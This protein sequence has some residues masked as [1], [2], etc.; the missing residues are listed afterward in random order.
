M[1]A[2]VN[3]SY[4]YLITRYRDGC[5]LHL[6]SRGVQLAKLAWIADSSVPQITAVGL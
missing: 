1:I 2:S 4:L 5:T 3:I 6:L